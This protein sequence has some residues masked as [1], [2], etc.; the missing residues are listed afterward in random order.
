MP[1][2]IQKN[3]VNIPPGSFL[4]PSRATIR[5]HNQRFRQMQCSSTC[6]QSSFFPATIILWN[7]LSQRTIDLSTHESFRV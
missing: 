6:Y 5:G 2:K 7:S 1:Y 4:H 3:L